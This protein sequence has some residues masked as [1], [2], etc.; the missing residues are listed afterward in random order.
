MPAD[1]QSASPDGRFHVTF[2]AWEASNSLWVQT[3]TVRDTRDNATVLRFADERWSLD[4][5]TWPSDHVALLSL[6]KF[7]GNHRPSGITVA[8]DCV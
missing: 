2:E 6:R 4:S 7:P 3:P 1:L 8:L 5:S